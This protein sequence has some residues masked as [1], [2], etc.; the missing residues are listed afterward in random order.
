MDSLP[1]ELL[2]II[3]QTDMATYYALIRTYP[4]FARLITNGIRFDYAELF[5]IDYHVIHDD[6]NHIYQ[7][8]WTLNGVLH[9]A[10]GPAIISR[11]GRMEYRVHGKLHRT[12]GPAL[13]RPPRK[14]KYF[15]QLDRYLHAST[16]PKYQ[17]DRD[18][19]YYYDGKL[20]RADGPAVIKTHG[21]VKYY[22]HG[23]AVMPAAHN[24]WRAQ[25]NFAKRY[26]TKRKLPR[27]FLCISSQIS[28]Q[29]AS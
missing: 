29:I 3:A 15:Y 11:K 16:D 1:N 27:L 2:H 9:R 8:R 25:F 13:I 12:D 24:F 23:E 14:E 26:P 4:R 7:S 5:G 19:E 22:I 6:T 17:S 28:S 21:L 10:D 18:L 20:H